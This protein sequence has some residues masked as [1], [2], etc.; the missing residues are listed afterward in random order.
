MA[1]FNWL[2]GVV[3]WLQTDG[4][5]DVVTL[6][7]AFAAFIYVGFAVA[8]SIGS[9]FRARGDRAKA[10]LRVAAVKRTAEHPASRTATAA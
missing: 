2:Q 8:S 1:I 10:S 6:G 5:W 9:N 7:L 3:A 4:R